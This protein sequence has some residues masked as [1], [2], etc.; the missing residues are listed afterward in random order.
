MTRGAMILRPSRLLVAAA[1]LGAAGS[2]AS[3]CREAPV[4]EELP[5]QGVLRGT[6]LYNG[7]PPC[8]EDGHVLGEGII[9]LF[10]EK[11]LPPPEGLASRSSRIQAISGD[12]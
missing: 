12:V 9:L 2:F 8:T 10:D 6:F 5:P 7:P 4:R 1:V 3:A 11:L